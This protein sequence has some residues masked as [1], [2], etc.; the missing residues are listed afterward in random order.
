MNTGLIRIMIVGLALFC[1]PAVGQ[2]A[3]PEPRPGPAVDKYGNQVFDPSKN[4]GDLVQAMKEMFKELRTSDRDLFDAKMQGSEKFQNALR[5]AETRRNNDLAAQKNDF[6]QKLSQILQANV[7]DKSLLLAT[8]LKEVKTDLSDRTTKLEQFANEQR[9]RATAADPTY[10]N[11]IQEVRALTQAKASAEGAGFGR[12]EIY[13]MFG[14]AFVGLMM[15]AAVVI[16]GIGLILKR[17]PP[18]PPRRNE[19]SEA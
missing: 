17:P 12:G 10:A 4:V 18:E 7:N 14:A 2:V 8:Q 15:F 3:V 11:M 13:A 5:D 1:A 16:A 9:G 6:D 19:T